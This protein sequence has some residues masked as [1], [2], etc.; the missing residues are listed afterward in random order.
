MSMPIK[1]INR[2]WHWTS[3][4]LFQVHRMLLREFL[5]KEN[6]RDMRLVEDDESLRLVFQG[7]GCYI[8]VDIKY[9][10][11]QQGLRLYS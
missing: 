8:S 4:V 9:L 5:M 7:G 3:T 1:S 6:V 11:L 2:Y 10:G